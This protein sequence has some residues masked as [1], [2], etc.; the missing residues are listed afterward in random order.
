MIEVAKITK[1]YGKQKALDAVSFKLEKGQITGFLGPNGAGKSTMMKI[2]TGF[3]TP[4]EGEA[5]VL[6]M[7]VQKEALKIQKRLGYL[8]EHN[9]LREELYI[10][11]YLLYVARVYG[12]QAP[13]KR[14]EEVM[15]QTGL[16]PERQK[17]I[18]NLSK[19]YKQR[20]GLAQALI[21]DPDVLILDEPTTGLDPN[22]LVEIRTLIKQIGRDKTVLLSTHIMQEVEAVCD[23]VLILN[24]GKLIGD[25]STDQSL[26]NNST[27]KILVGFSQ[28][29]EKELIE[30]LPFATT[31]TKEQDLFLIE[32][33]ENEDIRPLLFQFAKEQ[34]LSLLHLSKYKTSLEQQFRSLTAK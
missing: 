27:Q 30:A 16:L 10:K 24:N 22:Q 12:K 8:P 1:Y 21:P 26:L 3:L 13:L 34:Q 6:G 4:D 32:S 31:V 28:E 5:T 23:R 29:V 2:L 9:P 7:N 11:E 33:T 19:G 18:K 25:S 17:K 15:Q 14:V 20:V